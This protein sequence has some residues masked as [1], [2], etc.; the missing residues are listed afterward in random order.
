MLSSKWLL[1]LSCLF[2]LNFVENCFWQVWLRQIKRIFTGS[3]E[4]EKGSQNWFCLHCD[5]DNGKLKAMHWHLFIFSSF[6]MRV[7]IG[8]T[9]FLWW[10]IY[11]FYA[12][13]TTKFLF[14]EKLWPLNISLV[15]SNL[16]KCEPSMIWNSKFESL[17]LGKN[18]N[19]ASLKTLFCPKKVFL[20]IIV[21]KKL[22]KT[23]ELLRMQFYLFVF[24]R[25]SN[26]IK[27]TIFCDFQNWLISMEYLLLLC[28]F[29]NKILISWEA[30]VF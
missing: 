12:P 26:S 22:Y 21:V 24:V 20:A 1:I 25:I 29:L 16:I 10:N 23:E 6:S 5:F 18:W 8:I 4:V 27:K 17:F 7:F 13:F 28:S 14:Q 3:F 11:F 15:M 9:C 2:L 30:M 19:S